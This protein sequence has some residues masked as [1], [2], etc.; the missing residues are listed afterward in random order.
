MIGKRTNKYEPKT[1]AEE[2]DSVFDSAKKEIISMIITAKDFRAS[3]SRYI[4][5][6]YQ[7]EAVLVK[8]RAGHFLITP[9]KK[10]NN[11]KKKAKGKDFAGD[12]R[13][14]LTQLMETMEG[15]RKPL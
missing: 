7:G 5:A 9:V 11:E 14:A 15:K 3:Q 13:Q 1:K 4:G 12:F 2:K 6:A 10:K 8:A